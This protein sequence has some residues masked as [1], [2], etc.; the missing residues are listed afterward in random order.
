MIIECGDNSQ[1]ESI[2]VIKQT[3]RKMKAVVFIP[4]IFVFAT[5]GLYLISINIPELITESGDVR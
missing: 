4:V 2:P 1:S 5:F 3:P